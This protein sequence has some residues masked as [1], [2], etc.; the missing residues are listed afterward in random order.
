MVG[1]LRGPPPRDGRAQPGRDAGHRGR[2]RGD[3]RAGRRGHA[4][5][6]ARVL[7]V[8][9]AAPHRPRR[10]PGPRHLG[11]ARR[12]VRL[13][14]RARPAPPRRVRDRVTPRRARR[15]RPG[16]HPGR[17]GVDGR[18]VASLGTPGHVRPGAVR[19]PAR[20]VPPGGRASPRSRTR[21]AGACGRRRRPGAS[22]VLFGLQS[23]TPFDRSPAW[24]ALRRP[25]LAG[26]T[27]RRCAIRSGARCSSPRRRSTRPADRPRPLSSCCRRG[28][29]A[30][31]ARPRRASPRT[32]SSEA[33][34]PAAAFIELALETDG[35]RGVQLPV[36]QPVPRRG[37]G[38]ARRSA[39]HARVWPMPAPTSARSWTPASPRS[40]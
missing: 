34:Q 23:R 10:P 29:P 30:T 37:R 9:D 13:R 11:H 7:D 6:C 15:R 4:G 28:R 31:T 16:R 14:R 33:C 12:A 22:G 21:S 32:P 19:P 40:S 38:D 20:A 24:Q 27:A 17:A 2:H 39:G 3:G 26:A 25:V 36:P 35:A 1:P 5:R 8:A 18:G